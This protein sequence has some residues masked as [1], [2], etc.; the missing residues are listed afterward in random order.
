M[1]ETWA[2]HVSLLLLTSSPAKK[3]AKPLTCNPSVRVI[4]KKNLLKSRGR[5][6]AS[7]VFIFLFQLLKLFVLYIIVLHLYKFEIQ[8]G[9]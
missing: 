7:P 4:L 6:G 8:K 2:D 1:R 5:S 9:S 3:M